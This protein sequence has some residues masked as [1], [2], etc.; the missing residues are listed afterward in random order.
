MALVGLLTDS[1]VL[2]G[3]AFMQILYQAN[4]FA[5]LAQPGVG[6]RLATFPPGMANGWVIAGSALGGF[7]GS[8]LGGVLADAYGFNAVNWMGAAAAA[9][10]VGVL[11]MTLLPARDDGAPD[12]TGSDAESTADPTN[13]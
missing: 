4:P 11:V 5:R 9:L 8:A 2:L 12:E 3:I 1:P 10:S 13:D 7:G 6:V